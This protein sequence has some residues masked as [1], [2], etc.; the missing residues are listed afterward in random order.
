MCFLEVKQK[1]FK[2][3]TIKSRIRINSFEQVNSTNSKQ[4]IKETL[5][6]DF[7]LELSLTNNFERITLVNKSINERVTIDTNL[8]FIFGHNSSSYNELVIVEV[9]Q[10]GYNRNTGIVKAL[11]EQ[12]S[13]PTGMSKYCIGIISLKKEMKYNRFKSKLLQIKK[14][15]N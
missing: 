8:S 12:R 14:I 2:G 6:T 13:Y 3:K 11:R 4:F 1:D 9:K 5:N 10:K 15:S 7:Q